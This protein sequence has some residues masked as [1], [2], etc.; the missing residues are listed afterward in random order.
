MF[1]KLR[2]RLQYYI[3]TLLF[4]VGIKKYVNMYAHDDH[5]IT[6][7]EGYDSMNIVNVLDLEIVNAETDALSANIETF[8][9]TIVNYADKFTEKFKTLRVVKEHD[10][11]MTT[12]VKS[13]PIDEIRCIKGHPDIQLR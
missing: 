8:L 3:E 1:R 9:A 12:L 10:D 7:R 2:E 11:G 13:G 6:L 5:R 4:A